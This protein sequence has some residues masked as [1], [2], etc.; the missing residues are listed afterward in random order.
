MAKL[1]NMVRFLPD[2]LR[3]TINPNTR[4]LL[5][6]WASS[7]DTIVTQIDAA[8]DQ[9]FVKNADFNFLDLLGSNV[10]VFRNPDFNLPDDTFRNLIP[11]LSYS[12][13]QVKNTIQLVLDVFFWIWK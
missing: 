7:D 5:T 9:I 13:K 1:D 10:G 12:P 2:V 11:L 8:K 6:A 3:P 4:G